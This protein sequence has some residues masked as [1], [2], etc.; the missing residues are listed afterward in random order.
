MKWRLGLDLGTN[1]IGWWAF[2]VAEEGQGE[3]RRWRPVESLDGGIRIFSEG[4]EPSKGGRIGDS[5]AVARRMAR[6]ARRN[7]DRARN[8]MERLIR[9]LEDLDLL[10]ESDAE[11]REIFQTPRKTHGDPDRYNPYR[12]RAEALERILEPYELGRALQHMGRRRGFKSNRKEQSDEEGGKL[13]ERIDRMRERLGGRTLGQYSWDTYIAE[14]EREKTGARPNGIRLRADTDFS[15]DRAMYADEFDRIRRRQQSHH[16]LSEADWDALKHRHILFQWP[17]RPVERGKCELRADQP[18]H[19]RDTPIGHDFRIYQEL[20]ALRWID[21]NQAAHALDREQRNAVLGLLFSRKSEVTFSA[22]R[23]LKRTDRTPFFPRDSH[24]NLESENRNG[25]KPHGIAARMADDVAL[26]AL[27]QAR[28]QRQDRTIDDIFEI[29]HSES[30]DAIVER[31]INEFALPSGT[32]RALAGLKLSSGTASISRKFMVQIVPVMRDRGLVYSDAVAE[33]TDDQGHPLH[34]CLRDDGRRWPSLPYYGEVLSQSMLGAN[35]K[36]DAVNF[37]E[38][39]FG[40]INNPTVHVA[41][42]Q[43]RKL[44]NE[45]IDRFGAAPVEVHVEL[46]RDLKLSRKRRNEITAAQGANQ[47]ENERIKQDICV[48][49]GVHDPSPRD[50]KKVKLWEELGKNQPARRCVFTGR[51]ISAAQLFNGEVEIEHLLPFARTLD[52]STSNLTVALRWANRLKGNRT[53]YEA[54]HGDAHRERGIVWEKILQRASHLLKAKRWRFAANAME[55]YEQ[56]GGFVARQLTDTAYIARVAQRYLGALEGVERVVPNPGRLTALVRGKWRLN[57]LLRDDNKKSRE[58]HRHHAIDAAVIALTDRAVLSQVSRLTARGVDDRV[59]LA[60]PVLDPG[61]EAAIR[62]RVPTILVSYKPDHGTQGRMYN[63]T[64]YGFVEDDKRDPDLPE[65]G[66]VTRKVLATLTAKECVA[67]RDP[68][69]RAQVADRL[70]QARIDGVKHE[71][72]LLALSREIGVKR[73]RIL[74]KNQTVRPVPSAPYKGY[75]P[76]S[77]VCCDVWRLP[78][79]RA[80]AWKSGR[81]EWRGVFWPYAETVDGAPDK[82]AKRPHPA[83]K[84]I[85]RLFKDDIVGYRDGGQTAIMRIG[86]FSTTNN[87]LDLKPQEATDAPRR[88]VSINTLCASGLY[89]LN[90][91]VDGRPYVGPRRGRL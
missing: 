37:P 41:L 9:K 56:E 88:Y 51:T 91:S 14:K 36:F 69:L 49:N 80:G 3:R 71:K 18:R 32:A 45:L 73:V 59:H 26:A 48:P 46:T 86:G 33:L 68:A 25:L 70:R 50:L 78:K 52:D 81:Y 74:V 84:Y 13:K 20:N 38:R 35:P 17:L 87:K 47:R 4:R 8:R 39:H 34:H 75:A 83:A 1:S 79:G 12:L 77:Y 63:E 5:L 43:V 67:I 2:R 31:L 19:W 27:W 53:P 29:L 58:D 44:V 7:R 30:D 55:H 21:R 90:L 72:A 89:K 82:E 54:F 6:A 61:L 64:A 65:H 57:G 60:A 15:P 62:A 22:L 28:K 76:D 11:R 10:P 24:F 16:G 85:M 40:K 42:N 23:K 66:L